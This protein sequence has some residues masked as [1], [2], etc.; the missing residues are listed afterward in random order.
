MAVTTQSSRFNLREEDVVRMVLEFLS[1][2]DLCISQLSVERE[3]G[4]TNGVFSDDL[5]FLR[6]LILDGQWDD[7]LQFVQPLE[8]VEAF[9]KKQFKY[10]VNKHKYVELLCIRSEAGPIHNVEIAVNDVVDCLNHLEQLCPNKDD[11]NELCLL[12]T[13]PNLTELKEYKNWNPSNWRISCFKAILPLIEKYL[14]VDK[15]SVDL[16]KTAKNDRLMQLIIKGILYESCVN[17]C[18]QKATAYPNTNQIQMKYSPLLEDWGFTNSDLSLISW[19]QS[20]P[21]STFSHPFEQK[22]LN[23]EV[24]QLEKPSLMASWSEVILVTPIKPKVFPHSATPFTRRKATDLMSKSLTPGLVD[25][26]T[27]SVMNFSINDMTAMSRSSFAATGFHLNANNNNG[28]NNSSDRHFSH[29][30]NNNSNGIKKGSQTS[31]DRLFEEGEVF[32]SSC[33]Q[34]LPT[35]SEK[36]SPVSTASNEDSRF[37]T[38]TLNPIQCQNQSHIPPDVINSAKDFN[39]SHNTP[40]LWQKFQKEKQRLLEKLLQEE[41]EL[42]LCGTSPQMIS[43]RD[44]SYQRTY[45]NQ[46]QTP[47]VYSEASQQ[48]TPIGQTGQA[49]YPNP[50]RLTTSTPKGSLYRIRE[51]PSF[52]ANQSPIYAASNQLNGSQRRNIS[53]ND[54][55]NDIVSA[56]IA[57]HPS[58]Q[59]S[60]Q[61]CHQLS[62]QSLPSAPIQQRVSRKKKKLF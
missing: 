34:R 31:V 41:E 36:P 54:S 13:I 46:I 33:F 50:E 58:Q 17:Y 51:T 37:L 59:S 16:P 44:N 26:L 55:V 4:L 21:C 1:N 19:L 39:T 22:T 14:P 28:D 8:S 49:N 57:S 43:S 20:I 56:S 29:N 40:D 45:A 30:N 38:E 6:Q 2:R 12:L 11:Y 7:V 35:I 10:L 27:K 62:R 23:V 48:V 47:V 61:Q 9:D 53:L 24:E 52:A 3:T 60:L 42:F 18:Q 5:L 32:S 15:K 25:G